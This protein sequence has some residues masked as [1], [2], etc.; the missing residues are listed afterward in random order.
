MSSD[1]RP[2]C[3]IV[4]VGPGLGEAL[5]RAFAG[6]GWRVALIARSRDT[7]GPLAEELGG[8]GFVCDVTNVMALQGT[9]AEIREG[10]GP[11]HTLLWNVGSGVWGNL[12][13]VDLDGMELAW[14]TNALGLFVAAQ[15][16]VGDMRVAGGGNLVVTGATAS[17]R[18]K[19]FTTAFAAGKAAQRSLCQSMARQ[20]W[21][22]G[23][24]VALVV[25][26]GMLDLPQTR[27]RMPD[28]PDEVFISPAAAAQTALHLCQQDR[29][30]WT[31]E[32]ELRP[33]LESW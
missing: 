17:R 30:A 6:A 31:F 25:F 18:G 33:H 29:T 1:E 14:R 13:E 4:G 3:V 12:D 20:L 23:I 2:L 8:T 21:P 28:K 10:Q 19:P 15:E 32:L 26:D 7:I 11:V 22:E 5:S 27:E 16:V 24:H 9:L